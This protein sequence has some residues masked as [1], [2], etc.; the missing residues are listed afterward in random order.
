MIRRPPRST[1]FPYTTLFRSPFGGRA[2]RRS[3]ESRTARS[4]S[5]ITVAATNASP[6]RSRSHTALHAIAVGERPIRVARRV[7]VVRAHESARTLLRLGRP[8][9]GRH[10]RRGRAGVALRARRLLEASRGLDALEPERHLAGRADELDRDGAR[11]LL[12]GRALGPARQ[13]W[14][15]GRR[16]RAPGHG[17]GP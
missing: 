1:L 17:P 14:C 6:G 2:P 11:L 8:R 5:A 13:P 15:H 10:D 7:I 4:T 3:R 9:G 16:R 12:L